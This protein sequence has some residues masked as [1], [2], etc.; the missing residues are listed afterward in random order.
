MTKG[1]GTPDK[2]SESHVFVSCACSPPPGVPPP[3]PML[4]LASPL[5]GEPLWAEAVCHPPASGEDLS[6]SVSHDRF[7]SLPTDPLS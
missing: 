4:D 7:S 2:E 3:H 6:S 5:L 1:Q